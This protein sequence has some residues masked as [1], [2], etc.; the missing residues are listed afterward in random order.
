MIY[1]R[2]EPVGSL[3]KLSE[4]SIYR[5]TISTALPVVLIAPPIYYKHAIG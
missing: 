2:D 4:I 3:A 5:I 1:T